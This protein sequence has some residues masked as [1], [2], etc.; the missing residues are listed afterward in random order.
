MNVSADERDAAI[1]PTERIALFD[2]KSLDGFYTWLKDTQYEDPKQVFRVTDGMLH[3]T[4]D[5]LGAVVTNDEYR[6]Y[7]CVIEFKWGPRAWPNRTDRARDSG[8]LVHSVGADGAYNGT[9]MPSL[10][11]QII[12]GGMGDFILVT[13]NDKDGN[14]VPLSLTCETDRDRD[15]EVI[16]KEGGKRETFDL[17][18]RARINW[19]GRDPDWDDVI[20]FHGARDLD[21]PTDQWNRMDV[22]CDGGHVEVYVNGTKANEGFDAFPSYGRLQLQTELAELFVRRWELWPLDGAPQPAAPQQ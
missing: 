4:G 18:N 6:D 1:R 2:G 13:G 16:W 3:V 17:E 11:A 5:G 14:P 9:W 8:L 12:E 7:H 10:E 19:W 22:I 15:G 20:G 21:S